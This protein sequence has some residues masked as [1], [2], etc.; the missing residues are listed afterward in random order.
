MSCVFEVPRTG[1]QVPEARS[2]LDAEVLNDA[3]LTR[4]VRVCI[5]RLQSSIHFASASISSCLPYTIGAES[6]RTSES[7]IT[8]PR[9]CIYNTEQAFLL[10]S[11]SV[12][13]FLFFGSVRYMKLSDVS[14]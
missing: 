14:F 7:A 11:F 13:H 6:R 12:F 9:S 1:D 5:L 4:V 8:L 3:E 10:F 2:A